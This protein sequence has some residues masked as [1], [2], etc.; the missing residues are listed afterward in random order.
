MNVESYLIKCWSIKTSSKWTAE[1]PYRGQ[2]GVTAMVINELFGRTILQ[3]R[4]EEQWHYYNSIN[5]QQFDFTR[6][7]FDYDLTYH[8]IASSRDEAFTD[9]NEFQYHELKRLLEKELS[10]V[11]GF[12]QPMIKSHGNS[13]NTNN[14]LL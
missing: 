13:I 12:N 14:N 7:Q 3:T 5:G 6:N 1:N 2:C 10:G 9:T 4:V 11:V 8:D